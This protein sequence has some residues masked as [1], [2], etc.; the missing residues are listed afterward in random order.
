MVI[1]HRN[2]RSHFDWDSGTMH[3]FMESLLIGPLIACKWHSDSC[4]AGELAV[5]ASSFGCRPR[6]DGT[7]VS[8]R[9]CKGQRRQKRMVQ[10]RLG[11]APRLF[12]NP[13]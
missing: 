2:Q 8:D 5:Q 4:S 7:L 13:A 6:L 3:F 12:R 1:T 10:D 11:I 9:G